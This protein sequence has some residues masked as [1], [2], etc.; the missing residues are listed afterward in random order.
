MNAELMDLDATD[1]RGWRE[2]DVDGAEYVMSADRDAT[3][4]LTRLSIIILR[5]TASRIHE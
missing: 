3:A 4:A 5:E 1:V 2:E